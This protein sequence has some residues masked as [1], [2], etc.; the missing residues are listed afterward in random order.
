MGKVGEKIPGIF[1]RKKPIILPEIPGG[2]S[3]R[4]KGEEV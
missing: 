1:L 2:I 4:K 3:L